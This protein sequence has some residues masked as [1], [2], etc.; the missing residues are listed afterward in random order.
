VD[1]SERENGVAAGRVRLV[2]QLAWPT[3]PSPQYFEQSVE[4]CRRLLTRQK[5]IFAPGVGRVGYSQLFT[6]TLPKNTHIVNK[7]VHFVI[8]MDHLSTTSWH[9]NFKM[10]YEVN[11]RPL[12]A[13]QRWQKKT[14]KEEGK[15]GLTDDD[16]GFSF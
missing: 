8:T 6:M 3:L 4:T 14:T 12:L 11:R 13:D 15:Q 10:I 2:G 1:V 16:G 7:D 5:T 9:F